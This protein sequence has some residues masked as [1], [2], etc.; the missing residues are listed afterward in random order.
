MWRVW[1]SYKKGSGGLCHLDHQRE[2]QARYPF[3]RTAT[4]VRNQ[5]F[6][7]VR[8][9]VHITVKVF[10]YLLLPVFFVFPNRLQWAAR[11]RVKRLRP[12]KKPRRLTHR[13][14]LPNISPASGASRS[15]P[16][17][18]RSHSLRPTLISTSSLSR[19]AQQAHRNFSSL[20]PLWEREG[21]EN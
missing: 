2:T 9:I 14:A 3:F 1:K 6:C 4:S 12:P 20:T 19:S 16:P 18:S 5:Q 13:P 7:P 8:N 10:I 17:I 11:T 15:K 21:K